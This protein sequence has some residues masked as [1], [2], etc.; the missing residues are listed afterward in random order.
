M[1]SRQRIPCPVLFSLAAAPGDT[2]KETDCPGP[3]MLRPR[4]RA[5][6]LH[7]ASAFG[8][9][10]PGSFPVQPTA[11]RQP[12][13]PRENF[14]DED[15]ESPA[16]VV[17]LFT[18]DTLRVKA[19]KSHAR[20]LSPV[21]LS[22]LRCASLFGSSKHHQ[23]GFVRARISAKSRQRSASKAHIRT[24]QL[25]IRSEQRGDSSSVELH[26]VSTTTR[27]T[28]R[29]TYGEKER[30]REKNDRSVQHHH[31]SQDP[32]SKVSSAPASFQPSAQA[33]PKLPTVS[34]PA[35]DHLGLRLYKHTPLFVASSS[36]CHSHPTTDRLFQALYYLP[37]ILTALLCRK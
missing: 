8:F 12:P 18:D 9:Q 14:G 17:S 3:D 35:C 25:Q 36:I 24:S 28:D 4:Q 33:Q 1:P 22:L 11:P 15:D 30:E 16:P 37:T 13:Q 7:S 19:Q 21:V 20:R 34:Q 5:L 10:I 29:H 23:V 26:Q 2:S 31:P 6:I 32:V 27:H